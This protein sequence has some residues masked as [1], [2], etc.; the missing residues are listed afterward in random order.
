MA[1]KKWTASEK[2]LA[3][4]PRYNSKLVSKFINCLMWD[5][6]KTVA[7]RVFYDAMDIIA[8]K[9]KD[10]SP[11]EVFEQAIENVKP[12]V[13]V[14]SKRIGGASYQIPMQVNEKRSLSLAIRWIIHAA[15]NKSGKPMSQ[16]L[17]SEIMAAYRKEG[18]AMATRENVH[19]MAEA[20]KAF[21]HFAK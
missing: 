14:R 20:N 16:R 21:A 2:Q 13:E 8:D 9:I 1:F 4:D 19:R 10:A 12:L 3:P 18:D 15:R 17:A 6:K 5:G 7:R 11:L